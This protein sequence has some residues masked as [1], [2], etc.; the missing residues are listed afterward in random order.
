EGGAQ[1]LTDALVARLQ[2]HGGRVLCDRRVTEIVVRGGRAVA[3]RTATGE[4]HD[5]RRAVVADVGAPALYR[6]LL[7]PEHVPA[8]VRREIDRFQ[9]DNAT[10]KVDWSL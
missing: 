7:A 1:R 10:V 9:Y 8:D 4:V 6:S 5:A 3:V 2:H